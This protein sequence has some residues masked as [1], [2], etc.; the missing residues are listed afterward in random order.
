MA[1]LSNCVEML[2]ENDQELLEAAL[3]TLLKIAGNI[4]RDPSNEKY[5]SVNL[6]SNVVEKKLIPAVG[7]L[8]VLFLMGFEEG[9]DKLVLPS[10][11][12][13]ERVNRYQKELLALKENKMK[14]NQPTVEQNPVQ[15]VMALTPEVQ[16]M[17]S[18]FKS[19]LAHEFERV[20]IYESPA[21]QEKS[22]GPA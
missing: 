15:P 6:S 13:L 9:E 10:N 1:E 4:L 21:L 8:E 17:E 2:L 5:R 11:D 19:Q 7:A 3:E 22:L 20:L 14:K 16:E 18:A 12:S